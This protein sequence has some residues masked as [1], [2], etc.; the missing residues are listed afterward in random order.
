[1]KAG[2]SQVKRKERAGY[3]VSLGRRQR[4]GFPKTPSLDD[5]VLFCKA[6]LAI[7][8]NGPGN[9]P[10]VFTA[11]RGLPGNGC[12]FLAS[13]RGKLD[14]QPCLGGEQARFPDEKMKAARAPRFSPFRGNQRKPGFRV[15]EVD[16][17]R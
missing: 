6:D 7:L 11:V 17:D 3:Q 16:R 8:G 10:Q 1:M 9:F 15:E 4:G 5:S 12:P 2:R 13:I 14:P